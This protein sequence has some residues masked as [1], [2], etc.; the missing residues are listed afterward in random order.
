MPSISS[1]KLILCIA[2]DEDKET[3]YKIRHNIYAAELNQ[4]SLNSS[5]Q[6]TDELDVENHYIIA[7]HQNEIIGFINLSSG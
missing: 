4:H 2:S 6:L 3:I 5:L 1:L 7:K